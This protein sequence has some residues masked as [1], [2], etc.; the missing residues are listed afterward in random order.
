ML[1]RVLRGSISEGQFKRAGFGPVNTVQGR[2]KAG[3]K[4]YP[5]IGGGVYASRSE[6][7]F[8]SVR[9]AVGIS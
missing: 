7:A 2:A 4:P 6:R 5:T 1:I 8:R 3:C 9:G